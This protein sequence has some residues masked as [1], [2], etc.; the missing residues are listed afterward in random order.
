MK[1]GSRF[2]N[3]TVNKTAI[4]PLQSRNR[5]P[6]G[7]T[8]SEQTL[9]SEFCFCQAEK[10]RCPVRVNI[11]HGDETKE[12]RRASPRVFSCFKGSSECLAYLN[13]DGT[14]LLLCLARDNPRPPLVT[15]HGVAV[16]SNLG[17]HFESPAVM[18]RPRFRPLR[19]SSWLF[20]VVNN[21]AVNSNPLCSLNK[22][23]SKKRI[24]FSDF[25]V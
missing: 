23:N 2:T 5:N 8:L 17:R 21:Q 10:E 18:G 14:S 19:A 16:N 20:S 3:L 25:V 6:T 13:P 4:F 11:C 1:A 24:H 9:T 22:Q 15:I 7:T 12:N